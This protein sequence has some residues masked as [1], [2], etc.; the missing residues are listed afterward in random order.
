MKKDKVLDKLNSSE[1]EPEISEPKSKPKD[2]SLED[3]TLN[4]LTRLSKITK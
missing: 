4:P 3:S 1:E 2:P